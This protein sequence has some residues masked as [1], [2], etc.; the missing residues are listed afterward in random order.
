MHKL[1]ARS[2]TM[3]RPWRDRNTDVRHA[4]NNRGGYNGGGNDVD[5]CGGND[6]AGD[7]DN[8]DNDNG[9]N[10]NGGNNDNGVNDNNG[11]DADAGG[12][13]SGVATLVLATNGGS[14]NGAHDNW[15]WDLWWEKWMRTFR[16]ARLVQELKEEIEDKEHN[17]MIACHNYARLD[18]LE[19]WTLDR[20]SK[21]TNEAGAQLR[22]LKDELR[23]RHA[24]DPLKSRHVSSASASC[25]LDAD[26]N[27]VL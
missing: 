21:Y 10:D 27:S 16:C 25:R 4:L 24:P 6:N 12:A 23:P 26:N 13:N 5:D 17:H 8:G 22:N 9:D 14:D 1:T 15:G 18:R 3:N 19:Q 7:N 20:H 2:H 11:G